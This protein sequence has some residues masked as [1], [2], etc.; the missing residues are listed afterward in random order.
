MRVHDQ[1]QNMQGLSST[2]RPEQNQTKSQALDEIMMFL[3]LNSLYFGGILKN[4]KNK[5]PN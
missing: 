3:N 2:W 5:G 1:Q 4:V